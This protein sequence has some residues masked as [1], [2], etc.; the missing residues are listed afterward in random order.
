MLRT[1]KIIPTVVFALL[2]QGVITLPIPKPQ[3]DYYGNIEYGDD[4]PNPMYNVS[5]SPTQANYIDDSKSESYYDYALKRK[6]VS[7]M[8]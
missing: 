5:N 7:P 2:I 8:P 4:F 1:N 3:N 6:K